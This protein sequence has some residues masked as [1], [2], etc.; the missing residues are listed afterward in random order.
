MKKRLL[1]AVLLLGTLVFA[2]GISLQKTTT[3]ATQSI[4][5]QAC[6]A[7]LSLEMMQTIQTLTKDYLYQGIGT[8]GRSLKKE[9]KETTAALQK[10]MKEFAAYVSDSHPVQRQL[11]ILLSTE[12]EFESLV[13]EKYSQENMQLLLDLGTVTSMATEDILQAMQT[14]S[15]VYRKDA[16]ARMVRLSA[17]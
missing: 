1:V 9:I 4:V 11:K 14:G 10:V 3:P 2:E 15:K 7:D 12:R 16:N 13:A 5:K 6:V 8:N 17:L